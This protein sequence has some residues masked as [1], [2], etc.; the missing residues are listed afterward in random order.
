MVENEFVGGT[1]YDENGAAVEGA[2]QIPSAV[3]NG[4]SGERKDVDCNSVKASLAAMFA[5]GCLHSR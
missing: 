4:L 2:S 5:G 1:F 3:N